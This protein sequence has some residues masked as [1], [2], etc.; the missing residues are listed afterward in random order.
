[1]HQ[2]ASTVYLFIGPLCSSRPRVLV[3]YYRSSFFRFLTR[4]LLLICFS[5]W[6]YIYNTSSIYESREKTLDKKKRIINGHFLFYLFFLL[7]SCLGHG[8]LFGFGSSN[9]CCWCCKA[10][11]TS[12]KW[13]RRNKVVTYGCCL[14]IGINGLGLLLPLSVICWTNTIFS[15]Y[16]TLIT[17]PLH[18][19]WVISSKHAT[20]YSFKRAN[21]ND[22]LHQHFNAHVN[23]RYYIT[24]SF[25]NSY[26]G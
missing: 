3:S 26:T 2:H 23:W 22:N 17:P 10:A 11:I 16:S 15:I 21:N 12:I 19:S 8:L 7:F 1:M 18:S 4:S 14:G 13:T 20:Y 25:A 6:A 5:R 9:L 24:V